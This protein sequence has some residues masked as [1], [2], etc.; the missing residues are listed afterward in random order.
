MREEGDGPFVSKFNSRGGRSSAT[1]TLNLKYEA[2]KDGGRVKV[3]E[4]AYARRRVW[5]EAGVGGRTHDLHVHP[6]RPAET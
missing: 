4:G 1:S 5:E 6:R 3:R 2:N